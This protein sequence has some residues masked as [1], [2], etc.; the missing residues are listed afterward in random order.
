MFLQLHSKFH[1]R[2][3][4][5]NYSPPRH[6]HCVHKRAIRVRVHTGKDGIVK[7]GSLGEPSASSPFA[8]SGGFGSDDLG[9]GL[10]GS[11]DGV[12]AST[13]YH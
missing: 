2:L 8:Y 11:D 7:D 12:R 9:G 3:R 10:R 13:G 5:F 1:F 4:I 6:R